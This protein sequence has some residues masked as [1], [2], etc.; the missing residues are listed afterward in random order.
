MQLVASRINVGRHPLTQPIQFQ[1]QWHDEESGLYYNRHRY[2]DPQ[3]GKYI[4]QDPIGL[5]GGT[6]LYGYVTNPISM[7]DPLGLYASFRTVWCR[8]TCV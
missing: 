8:D 3:Q 7:V 5:N 4:I 2:Y 1:G 6:H